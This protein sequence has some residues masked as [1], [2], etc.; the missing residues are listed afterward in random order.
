MTRAVVVELAKR[1]KPQVSK[2]FRVA[3]VDRPTPCL[4][5]QKG[6]Y[7]ARR[8][9][10]EMNAH[11][12]RRVGSFTRWGLSTA[13]A[14]CR[15]PATGRPPH[16]T[17]L[18]TGLGLGCP[19]ASRSDARRPVSAG[20]GADGTFMGRQVVCSIEGCDAP[21][22]ARGWCNRHYLRWWRHGD[23]E[24]TRL[25]WS[26]QP[27]R[28]VFD[29]C[30]ELPK[31]RGWCAKHYARWERNGDPEALV[32]LPLPDECAI[33]GCG[34]VPVARGWCSLHYGRWKRRG[35]PNTVLVT[36]QG[37]VCVV[38]GC[39]RPPKARGWCGRHYERWRQ[40]GNP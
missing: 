24:V 26:R 10:S 13:Y 25:A 19:S 33:E 38:E 21:V 14:P 36:K 30:G 4:A 29:G 9:L 2:G 5:V 12:D 35:D 31:A 22:Q 17:S 6:T 18:A 39:G 28:C 27:Q 3:L 20:G 1:E 40:Y 37:P 16:H 32:Q 23:P 11:R 34:R 15:S 7:R 8:C